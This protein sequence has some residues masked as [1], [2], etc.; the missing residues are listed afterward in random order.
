MKRNITLL[1]IT[2]SL[3]LQIFMIIYGFIIP[4]LIISYFGSEVN[5]L[6][7]SITQLL[8]YI[9][10]IEGG[11][12]S[13]IIAKLYSP[14]VNNNYDEVSSIVSTGTHFFKKIGIVFF[15]YSFI[16]AVVAPCIYMKD[17]FTYTYIFSLTIILSI[18]LLIQ[19]MMSLGLKC[20][21]N[22]DKKVYFIS[23]TQILIIII[24]IMLSY[25]SIKIYP[26]IH[27]FKLLTGIAYLI[28]PLMYS[29][30]IKKNYNLSKNVKP[31]LELIKDRWNGFANNLAYFIHTSTDITILTFITNLV[32]VSV[33]SVYSLVTTGLKSLLGAIN[34]GIFSTIGHLYAKGD[35]EELEKK[36]DLYEFGY[37]FI[38]FLTFTIASLLITP[39][40]ILYVGLANISNIYYKPVFGYLISCA[41]MLDLIKAPHVNLAYASNK[42]K[43]ITIPCFV[44]AAINI[45]V[46][47]ILV[48]NFGLI[49]VAIGTIC[50]MMYRI[51][52]QV[53]LTKKIINRNQIKFYKSFF[54]LLMTALVSFACCDTL[55][56]LDIF[57][58]TLWSW[59]VHAILYSII[60]SIIFVLI[61]IIIFPKQISGLL[62]YFKK[63]RRRKK[64]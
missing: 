50:A 26:S 7:S 39:F 19:Y 37:Q 6:V 47:I 34:T 15:A 5:G 33:Y 55:Y 12:T 16:L 2:S 30:F 56:E 36:F 9:S 58:I 1:N 54:F 64:C 53:Y 62:Y 59:L 63:I 13:V 32:T 17:G 14:L 22:A 4:K 21:L 10:L 20:L 3:L 45:V 40:V 48:F 61:S 41:I 38:V 51:I 60:C 24:S 18:G 46:S 8:S 43:E 28:Q 31:N 52:Y 42:F 35:L 11:I 49:G 57:N 44:E 27:L 29:S 23:I 25:V